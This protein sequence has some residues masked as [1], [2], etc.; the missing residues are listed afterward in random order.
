MFAET[1]VFCY[2]RG[3]ICFTESAE[4]AEYGNRVASNTI[5]VRIMIVLVVVVVVVVVVVA[6]YVAPGR[7]TASAA[8]RPRRPHHVVLD[9]VM[10]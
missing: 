1:G 9:Y 3:N 2:R 4:R 10:T 7:R 8:R 5:L 6:V